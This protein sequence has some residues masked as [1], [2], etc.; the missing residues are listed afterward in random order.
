M[1]AHGQV[2][3]ADATTKFRV[4]FSVGDFEQATSAVTVAYKNEEPDVA[5]KNIVA[6][7]SF[8]V[9][10]DVDSTSSCH[11]AHA[12]HAHAPPHTHDTHTTHDTH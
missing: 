12:R 6:A 11:T 7:F 9:K 10:D 8:V 5:G 4:G 3:S 1:G 2:V